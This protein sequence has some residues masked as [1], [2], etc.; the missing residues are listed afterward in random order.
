[1][2]PF[3]L[4]DGEIRLITELRQLSQPEQDAICT[5]VRQLV[6]AHAYPRPNLLGNVVPIVRN[7]K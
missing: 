6:E 7:S 2:R 5:T 3:Q 1:M 4:E